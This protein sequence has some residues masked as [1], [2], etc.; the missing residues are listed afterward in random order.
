MAMAQQPQQAAQQ[1]QDLALNQFRQPPAQAGVA[2]A[3]GAELVAAPQQGNA[4]LP[5]GTA[6]PR[7]RQGLDV[8]PQ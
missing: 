4:G 5:V 8:M 1:I 7:Q 2:D 3:S 6:Q